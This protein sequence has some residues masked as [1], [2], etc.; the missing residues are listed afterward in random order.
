MLFLGSLSYTDCKRTFFS[1]KGALNVEDIALVAMAPLIKWAQESD[2]GLNGGY[3]T[4]PKDLALLSSAKFQAFGWLHAL[5]LSRY[6]R[7][8]G[9]LGYS[10]LH[11]GLGG[12]L[13]RFAG[14]WITPH[15]SFSLD[16]DQFPDS[17]KRKRA[18]LW[19]SPINLSLF[20]KSPRPPFQGNQNRPDAKEQKKNH[21]VILK[22]FERELRIGI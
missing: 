7:L 17:R 10:H 3:L 6:D 12:N 13:N 21:P 9:Y 2:A 18:V 8:L 14:S 1:P 19:A 4:S 20:Q 11:H 15:T 22:P 16:Q 5:L